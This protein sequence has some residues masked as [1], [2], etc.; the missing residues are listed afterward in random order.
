MN[1]AWCSYGISS[2]TCINALELPLGRLQPNRWPSIVWVIFSRTFRRTLW[3][4]RGASLW[5]LDALVGRFGVLLGPSW[6]VVRVAWAPLGTS[7]VSPGA[8]MGCLGV[9]WG[10]LGS[11]WA[12]LRGALGLSWG[13]LRPSW[14]TP[15]A[16]LEPS[17]ATSVENIVITSTST[18]NM[19]FFPERAWAQG[20]LL[21]V[22]PR[23]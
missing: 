17:W 9:N 14:A 7:C 22:S 10:C 3:M 19:P 4:P 13:P 6:A 8:L 5:H 2:E 15:R 16:P 21:A 18:P 11:S 1:T 12:R 20:S 23:P